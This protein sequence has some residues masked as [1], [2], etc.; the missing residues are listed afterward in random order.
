[1]YIALSRTFDRG[2]HAYN[3]MVLRLRV[4]ESPLIV[5]AQAG[6]STRPRA[7][8]SL[9]SGSKVTVQDG[10]ATGIECVLYVS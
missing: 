7:R 6:P 9:T 2:T 4:G 1:M 8:S 5:S 10:A 3:V